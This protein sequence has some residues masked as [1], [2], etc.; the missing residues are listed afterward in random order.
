M[1]PKRRLLTHRPGRGTHASVHGSVVPRCSTREPCARPVLEDILSW[2]GRLRL[3]KDISGITSCTSLMIDNETATFLA[4]PSMLR[5][6]PWPEQSFGHDTVLQYSEVKRVKA[7]QMRDDTFLARG[8]GEWLEA[9]ALAGR[10]V[11]QSHVRALRSCMRHF[12]KI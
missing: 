8:P 4:I 5:H 11:A 7:N 12:P 1:A 9:L 6:S 2:I 3:R 10:A